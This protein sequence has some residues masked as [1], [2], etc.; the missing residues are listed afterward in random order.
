MR[1]SARSEESNREERANAAH[2]RTHAHT[3]TD[4]SRSH[5]T[6]RLRSRDASVALRWWSSCGAA[7]AEARPS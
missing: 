5:V 4:R 3:H 7:T 2:A 1:A 6:P